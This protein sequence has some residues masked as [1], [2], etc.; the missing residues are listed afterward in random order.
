MS[1]TT[2]RAIK[3]INLRAER[4]GNNARPLTLDCPFGDRL[5]IACLLLAQSARR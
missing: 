4:A 1:Q 5:A 3:F 2:D